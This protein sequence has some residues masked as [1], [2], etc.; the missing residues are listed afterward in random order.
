MLLILLRKRGYTLLYDM[1][2]KPKDHAVCVP[3]RNTGGMSTYLVYKAA[4]EDISQN[5]ARR[6]YWAH[7]IRR[8]LYE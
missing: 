4:K 7:E 5:H 1:E 8:V 2:S 6:T 3:A